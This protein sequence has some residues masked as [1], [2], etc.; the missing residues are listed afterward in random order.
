MES[1]PK[2]VPNQD[3]VRSS[4]LGKTPFSLKLPGGSL[5]GD[6]AMFLPLESS[7]TAGPQVIQ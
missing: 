3:V 1:F 6:A 2:P 5:R 7:V 4:I